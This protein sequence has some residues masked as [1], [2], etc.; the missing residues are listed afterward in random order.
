[1]EKINTLFFPHD[2][3]GGHVKALDG[4]RGVAILL[5]LLGHASNLQMYFHDALHFNRTGRIGVYCF[6]VLS[7]FLLDHQ[8]LVALKSRKSTVRFWI[9]YALRRFVR[10]WPL[11]AIA[12]LVNGLATTFGL[13]TEID[14][15]DEAVAH[16]LLL[17]G[18]GV[19]WAIPVE[20][21]YYI[22]SPLILFFCHIVLKWKPI[23][24]F[25][26]LLSGLVGSALLT[27]YV[28]F[29]NTSILEYLPVFLVGTI[30][31]VFQPTI[32]HA[33]RGWGSKAIELLAWGSVAAML[34]TFPYYWKEWFGINLD[35][36]SPAFYVPYAVAWSAIL[37]AV[38]YGRGA[39]RRLLEW[40]ILRYLG[41]VSYSLYLFHTP[42]LRL[43]KPDII[44]IPEGLKIYLFFLLTFIVAI[45]TYILFE[46]PLAK[47]RLI[48]K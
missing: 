44:P 38:R 5:V 30:I 43:V 25:L 28:E 41:V 6:F 32:K 34:A 18:Q 29:S 26:F 9:H 15:M 31:S 22:L 17:D 35:T 47:I 12:L 48:K 45:A 42:I 40:R 33:V 3:K 11:F 27:Y 16:L 46:R 20:V 10:I 2:G 39:V 21:K 36:F 37:V 4:L 1:M 8:I 23:P 24:T 13:K 7:A 19:F 14:S